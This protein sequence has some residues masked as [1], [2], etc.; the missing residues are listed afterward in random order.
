M[1]DPSGRFSGRAESY[2]RHRPGY[3][4]EVMELLRE[5]CG[6]VP[7]AAVADVGSGTGNLARLFLE[8]G[9]LVYGVEPNDEMR[10]VGKRLLAP[11]GTRFVSVAG[12]AEETTLPSGRVGFV[13]AGQAFH[14]FDR[15]GARREFARILVPGGWVALVWNERRTS[16]TPFLEGYERMLLDLGTDYAAVSHQ[17]LRPD[18]FA[19]FFGGPYGERAFENRQILDLD[20]LRGRLESTSYVPGRGEAGWGALEER[21]GGLFREHEEDGR[22]TLLYDCRVYYGRLPLGPPES[23]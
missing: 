13:S 3:P 4:Q 20:G 9:N 12:A 1:S 2:A 17:N 21:L 23:L 10:S 8:N 11:Y 22:I 7:E 19:A 18:D 6:L 5:E 14:W 16:G 15:E